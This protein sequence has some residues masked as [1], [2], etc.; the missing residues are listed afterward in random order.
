MRN[1]LAKLGKDR[2]SGFSWFFH[3]RPILAR[4]GRQP[5]LKFTSLWDGC[6]LNFNIP[7]S[8]ILQGYIWNDLTPDEWR[9]KCEEERRLREELSRI[10]AKKS[11]EYARDLYRREEEAAK[12]AREEAEGN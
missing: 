4:I 2:D 7:D 1:E 12:K 10:Q 11:R 5:P 8:K 3:S 9:R 6:D